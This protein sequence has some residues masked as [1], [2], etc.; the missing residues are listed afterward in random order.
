MS[1]ITTIKVVNKTVESGEEE[2]VISTEWSDE[3]VKI[4]ILRN[5][6]TPLVGEVRFE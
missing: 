5:S 4:I 6:N 3:K 2:L 1:K